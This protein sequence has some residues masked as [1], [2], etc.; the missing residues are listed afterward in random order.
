MARRLRGR[1]TLLYTDCFH[2]DAGYIWKVRLNETAKQEAFLNFL[3]EMNHNELVSLA[4]T[5][6]PATA[7]MLLPRR[8]PARM[9]K[10][11]AATEKLLRSHRLPVLKIDLKGKDRLEETWRAAIL[12]DWTAYA[13]A[14]LN[15]AEPAETKIIGEL[16]A[17][18]RR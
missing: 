18:M 17:A 14:K 6:F 8:L 10:R 4:K 7:V 5:H 3:P 1:L 13:L 15:G 2:R 11:F 9:A 16:K 12:A